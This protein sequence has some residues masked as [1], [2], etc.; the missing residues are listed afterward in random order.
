MWQ[1]EGEIINNIV[2]GSN[3]FPEVEVQTYFTRA[4]F[5]YSSAFWLSYMH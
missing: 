3:K 5:S 2:H 4:F 1:N